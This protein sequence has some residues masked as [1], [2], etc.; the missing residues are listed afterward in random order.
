[1]LPSDTQT[2]DEIKILKLL[3]HL[4]FRLTTDFFLARSQILRAID[5]QLT[6]GRRRQ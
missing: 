3:F 2:Y 5:A 1:V 6:V 4:H